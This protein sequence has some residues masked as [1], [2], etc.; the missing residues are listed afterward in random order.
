LNSRLGAFLNEAR[1]RKRG[2]G[3]QFRRVGPQA[4]CL[5]HFETI[6]DDSLLVSQA[7]NPK[8]I[9]FLEPRI[10]KELSSGASARKLAGVASDGRT[11]KI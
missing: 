3:P 11:R 2:F 5:W 6:P 7:I 1:R 8:G 10:A 9:V 4:R